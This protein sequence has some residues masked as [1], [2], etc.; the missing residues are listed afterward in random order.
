ML[1]FV[2]IQL[3]INFVFMYD[4][5]PDRIGQLIKF[6]KPRIVLT[7]GFRDAGLIKIITVYGSGF[8][9][10]SVVIIKLI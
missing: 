10:F 3:E 5:Y 9:G 6:Y 2:F 7:A 1:K 4:I 8:L